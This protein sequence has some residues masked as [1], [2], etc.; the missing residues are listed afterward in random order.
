MDTGGALNSIR[1][2]VKGDVIVVNGDS[3]LNYDYLKFKNFNII[4]K[5]FNDFG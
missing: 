4:N 5:S 3:Y 2:K 1:K